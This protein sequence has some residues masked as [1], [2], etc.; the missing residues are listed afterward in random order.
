[1]SRYQEMLRRERAR[2]SVRTLTDSKA[3]TVLKSLV[4]LLIL[5][6]ALNYNGSRQHSS[7]GRGIVITPEIA[8]RMLRGSER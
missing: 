2:R 7:T 6:R 8:A 5:K 3:K 4:A 1:M